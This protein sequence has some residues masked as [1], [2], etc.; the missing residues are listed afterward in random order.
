MK[1]IIFTKLRDLVGVNHRVF[2]FCKHVVLVYDL[3]IVYECTRV[4]S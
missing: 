4:Y 2:G 1:K 3:C